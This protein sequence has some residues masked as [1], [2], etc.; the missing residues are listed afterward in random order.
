MPPTATETLTSPTELA[1]WALRTSTTTT[2]SSAPATAVEADKE[3]VY[4]YEHLLPV[5]DINEKYPPL[6]PFEHVDP[7]HRALSH[8]NPL[9]FLHS[10]QAKTSELTPAVGTEIQGVNLLELNNDERDQLALLVARR[11]VVVLKDQ[12]QVGIIM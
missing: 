12:E 4:K 1:K 11:G 2:D 6:E 5:F 8:E 3:E 7:G 10:R 9:S